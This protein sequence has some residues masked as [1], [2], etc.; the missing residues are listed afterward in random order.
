M[1]LSDRCQ[2][3][4]SWRRTERDRFGVVHRINQSDFDDEQPLTSGGWKNFCALFR[5]GDEM[6]QPLQGRSSSRCCCLAFLFH[7]YS[8]SISF[9]YSIFYWSVLIIFTVEKDSTVHQ[10]WRRVIKCESCVSQPWKLLK[11]VEPKVA[12]ASSE[13]HRTLQRWRSVYK[14]NDVFL[15]VFIVLE[16]SWVLYTTCLN[17]P[18][19]QT[20]LE[21]WDWTCEFFGVEEPPYRTIPQKG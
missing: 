10:N 5:G 12:A 8:I 2:V 15:T 16:Y 1:A 14:K 6:G 3:A 17:P 13:D 7:F 18:A 21:S 4:K 9:L 20:K 11:T 19:H